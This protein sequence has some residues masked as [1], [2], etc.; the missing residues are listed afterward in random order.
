MDIMAI[1]G[2][3]AVGMMSM[4]REYAWDKKDNSLL[5]WSKEKQAL[6]ANVTTNRGDFV[7]AFDESGKLIAE[8]GDGSWFYVP[9]TKSKTRL[10]FKKLPD[11]ELTKA[12]LDKERQTVTRYLLSDKPYNC[13]LPDTLA[14]AIK[15]MENKL[16]EIP[17][18]SRAKASF[19]FDTTMEYGETYPNIEITFQEHETDKEIIRRVQIER[20]RARIKGN[21]ERA[22]FLK[23]KSKLC[24]S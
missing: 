18:A 7:E 5:V 8:G 19:R 2:K 23:L 12:D 22:Q 15:W 10:R 4:G 16:A 1:G 11:P 20:E 9:V 6:P 21:E 3:F 14:G 17:R 13:D 24:I